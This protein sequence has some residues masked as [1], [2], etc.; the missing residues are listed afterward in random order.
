MA[1]PHKLICSVL[2]ILLGSSE[3]LDAIVALEASRDTMEWLGE[4]GPA[5]HQ[6]ALAD[7]SGST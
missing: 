6:R 7:G 1:A 5:W 4:T 2:T 3:D